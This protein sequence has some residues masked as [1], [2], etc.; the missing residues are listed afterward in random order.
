VPEPEALAEERSPAAE[1]RAPAAEEEHKEPPD[2]QLGL[3]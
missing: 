3:F 1:E 2:E